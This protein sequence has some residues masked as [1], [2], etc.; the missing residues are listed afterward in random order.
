M[1]GSSTVIDHA[2]T[3]AIGQTPDTFRAKIW[4]RIDGAGATHDLVEHMQG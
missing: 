4:I 3:E 2:Q 1:A